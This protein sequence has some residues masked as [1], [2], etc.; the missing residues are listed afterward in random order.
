MIKN[1]FYLALKNLRKRGIRS[2]LTLIG[3]IIGVSLVVTLF[4]LGDALKTTISSQFGVSSTEMISVRAKGSSFGGPPGRG[5]V[6]PLTEKELEEIKK[7]SSVKK[8]VRRNIEQATAEIKR[9]KFRVFIT[10]IPLEERKFFY[11]MLDLK[12]EEGRF[13]E[14]GDSKKIVVGYNFFKESDKRISSGDKIK[15]NNET[16][17]VIGILKKKGSFIFDNIIFMPEEDMK[18]LFD[19]GDK[20]DII[21]VLPNSKDRMEQTK[22]EIEKTLRKIRN[23]KNEKDDF[24][25]STPKA[26]LSQINQIITGVQIF[27]LIL[28]SISIIVGMIGISN[29]MF[30][31]VLERTKDIGI[32]KSIGAKNSQIFLLFLIESGIFGFFGGLFGISIGIILGFLG[33]FS[34][35]NF[36]NLEIKFYIDYIFLFSVLLSSFVIGVFSGLFPAYRAAKQNPV[37][38]LRK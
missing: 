25:V 2:W 24:E 29:T 35:N 1:Y 22:E 3:I 37:E 11:E 26:T 5:A 4:L 19:F 32:M 13:F 18:R 36:L 21:A 27:V 7:I 33:I 14:A 6:N 31:S 16:F 9:K 34:L 38:S 17:D 28:A 10:N 15:I 8:A 12:I 23:I 30:T 20:I